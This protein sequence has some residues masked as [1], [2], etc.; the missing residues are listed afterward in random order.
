VRRDLVLGWRLRGGKW[1]RVPVYIDGRW[2]RRRRGSRPRHGDG[3]TGGS[4]KPAGSF[5]FSCR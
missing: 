3:R 2:R 5:R 4:G 1:R